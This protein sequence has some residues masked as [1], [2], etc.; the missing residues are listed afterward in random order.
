MMKR[1]LM[2]FTDDRAGQGGSPVGQVSDLSRFHGSQ[3]GQVSD[4]S[5]FHRLSEPVSPSAQRADE[6]CD[7]SESRPT[8][9]GS[10]SRPAAFGSESRPAASGWPNCLGGRVLSWVAALAVFGAF[11]SAALAQDADEPMTLP[12]ALEQA[13]S[14]EQNTSRQALSVIEADVVASLAD[15]ATRAEM[16]RTLLNLLQSEE[17]TSDCKAWICRQ[18]EL[19]GSE[20][21]A[22]ALG[23]LVSNRELSHMARYALARIPGEAGTTA[24]IEALD[25]VEGDLRIGVINSL[26]RRGDAAAL[27]ALGEAGAAAVEDRDAP[28]LEAVLR[29]IGRIGGDEAR[30]AADTWPAVDPFQTF[31]E[32]VPTLLE[33][34]LLFAMEADDADARRESS[35][36][37]RNLVYGETPD[38]PVHMRA[39]GLR[40]WMAMPPDEFTPGE[41][42]TILGDEAPAL[43]PYALAFIADGPADPAVAAQALKAAPEA[44][45][46]P[47]ID[48]LARRGD[49]VA[50][51]AVLAWVVHQDAGVRSAAVRALGPLGDASHVPLLAA[52]AAHGDQAAR[53]AL[54]EIGDDEAEG[55]MVALLEDAEPE[56]R[57]VV[58]RALGAR[59]AIDYRDDLADL[60]HRD[61]DADVRLAATIGL[62]QMPDVNAGKKVEYY[63]LAVDHADTVAETRQVLDLLQRVE[64]PDAMHYAVDL[65]V[66]RDDVRIG[67]AKSAIAIARAIGDEH[68]KDAAHSVRFIAEE[69][70]D[71]DE[72]QQLA[73]DAIAHI[74]RNEG[75]ITAWAIAGPYTQDEAG[76]EPIFIHRFAPE[77]ETAE[78]D[79]RP[80]PESAFSP[81]GIYDLNAAIGGGDRAAYLK[82]IIISDTA[83][84]AR[85]EI[86]SDDGVKAWLD[87]EL[88]HENNV[89]RG[90]TLNSDVVEVSLDEGENVLM[91]KITQGGGDWKAAC[92]VRAADGFAIE[93]VTFEMPDE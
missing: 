82:A 48:A 2:K 75:F 4:L 18:L 9:F 30:R 15:D 59:R 87:G 42:V 3:V 53:R 85:L 6:T 16:E 78:V 45:R 1:V 35:S 34:A 68:T 88:V 72:I 28:T 13:A 65:M 60:A 37:Y 89:M 83:Q 74:E 31:P 56:V 86:G 33:T 49:A 70:P 10:E 62:A 22:S 77:R 55:A 23:S 64:H 40:A 61:D 69:F 52:R 17:A 47:L 80:M 39:A 43:R 67:A 21:S 14:Y 20:A 25:D 32:I 11:S 7:G 44:Q 76:E 90:L 93:G 71:N 91:L 24:L 19:I 50:A 5:G 58:A 73:G 66:T 92:R 54:E 46:A 27:D 26:G 29:A 63:K 84:D 81:P 38:L 79:W 12:E 51:D 41:L 57:A 8:T 36:I